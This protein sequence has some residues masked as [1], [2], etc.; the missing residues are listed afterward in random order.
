MVTS[1]PFAISNEVQFWVQSAY[2][3]RIIDIHP[4]V[5][6]INE[7]INGIN[8][9]AGDYIAPIAVTGIVLNM[10]TLTVDAGASIALS[11]T[12]APANATN[13][14]VIWTSSAP[15]VAVVDQNGVVTGVAAGTANITAKTVDGEETAV[16]A[17]T[18]TAIAVTALV[19]DDDAETIGIGDEVTLKATITPANATDKTVTWTTSDAA[20]ATV[21]NGVVKGIAAGTATITA[22]SSNSSVTD[23]FAVTVSAG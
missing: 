4:K 3:T 17:V 12:I 18:V 22:T 6:M 19:L 21:T 7:E 15:S 10:P 23:A 9:L 1:F 2:D 8:D 11:P 20:V 13:Q 14:K 16:C 5:F